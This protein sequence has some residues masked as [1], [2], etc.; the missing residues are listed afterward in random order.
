MINCKN[1]HCNIFDLTIIAI[2]IC[3]YILPVY[4]LRTMGI[5]LDQLI[6]AMIIIV[7]YINKLWKT[8]K[9]KAKD[10]ILLI[11]ILYFCFMHRTISHLHLIGLIVL[12]K[13]IDKE[14]RILQ[15]IQKSKVLFISLMFVFLYSSIYFDYMGRYVYTGLREINQS[16][17]ALI[18]LFLM[19]RVM[20]KN[21]G[22]I[23][24]VL[25]MLTFSKSYLL[26]II[27]FF[28]VNFMEKRLIFKSKFIINRLKSFKFIAISLFIALILLAQ[29]FTILYNNNLLNSYGVGWE[30][31]SVI[32]DHSNYFRFTTNT[33]LLE[34]YKTHPEKLLYGLTSEEFIEYSHKISIA[35]GQGHRA[36]RPH[37]YFFSYL[38]IY[39]VFALVIF[40]Y[41]STLFKRIVTKKNIKIF[42]VIFSYATFLGIGFSSY[43]L[44]LSVFTMILYKYD[45]KDTLIISNDIINEDIFDSSFKTR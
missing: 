25:G 45:I 6:F 28:V 24:I 16:G 31:Y 3:V 20:H 4:F 8:N 14:S 43:W 36:I 34:I 27:I 22:N 2:F 11:T 40:W 12:D 44:F 21:I 15:Y 7:F 5:P 33:N 17:Y 19:V 37:N 18:L 30:R 38:R 42:L 41:I 10:L 23:L 32:A 13:M 29:Y 9:T 35:K 1:I 39:G 26:G